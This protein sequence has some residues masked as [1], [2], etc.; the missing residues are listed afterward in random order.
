MHSSSSSEGTT[1]TVSATGFV[2]L[3]VSTVGS[4]VSVLIGVIKSLVDAQE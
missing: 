1:L 4:V 2:T 3:T